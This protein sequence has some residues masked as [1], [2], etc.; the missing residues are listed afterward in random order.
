MET[1]RLTVMPISS[2]QEV[3]KA[4]SMLMLYHLWIS[5]CSRREEHK[6]RLVSG[7]SIRSAAEGTLKE[8][9]LIVEVSPSLSLSTDKNLEFKSRTLTLYFIHDLST[10]SIRSTYN[11]TDSSCIESVDKVML[12][13]LVSCGDSDCTDLVESNHSKPELVVTLKDK[14]DFVALLNSKR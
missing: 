7:R 2:C 10:V 6:S 8:T 12:S 11:S 3:A 14:H 9:I 1:V 4:I 5:C 13:K